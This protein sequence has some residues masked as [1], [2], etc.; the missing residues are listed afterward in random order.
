MYSFSLKDPEIVLVLRFNW[1]LFL[2]AYYTCMHPSVISFKNPDF[3]L[4]P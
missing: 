3:S 4:S 2:S 1:G